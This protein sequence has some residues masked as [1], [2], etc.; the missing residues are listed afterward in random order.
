MAVRLAPDQIAALRLAARSNTVAVRLRPEHGGSGCP[1]AWR[2]LVF[3]RGFFSIDGGDD[4][5][6]ELHVSLTGRGL[7]IADQLFA[8]ADLSGEFEDVPDARRLR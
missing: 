8:S 1:P 2:D 5:T 6:H 7:Q 3:K 4:K